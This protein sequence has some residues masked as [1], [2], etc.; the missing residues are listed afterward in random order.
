[1]LAVTFLGKAFHR[2]VGPRICVDIVVVAAVIRSVST[3]IFDTLGRM[4]AMIPTTS[5]GSKVLCVSKDRVGWM[6]FSPL[7]IVG[8]S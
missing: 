3:N 2:N 5:S 7:V 8:G 1:M 4:D 6:S